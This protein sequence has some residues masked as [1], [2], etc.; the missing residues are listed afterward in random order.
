MKNDIIFRGFINLNKYGDQIFCFK[1]DNDNEKFKEII[2]PGH[3]LLYNVR[4]IKECDLIANNDIDYRLYFGFRL[5]KS[6]TSIFK[7][8]IQ[9]IENQSTPIIYNGK[10]PLLYTD[11][12]KQNWGTLVKS[13]S[14]K[15]KTDFLLDERIIPQ[16]ISLKEVHEK[17]STIPF[18]PYSTNEMEIHKLRPIR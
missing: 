3:I 17:N 7:E 10:K 14:K 16:N 18:F 11:E 5:T 13:F 6:E 1:K 8:N 15:F 12:Q 4:N 2:F 9:N